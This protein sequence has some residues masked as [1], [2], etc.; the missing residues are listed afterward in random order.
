MACLRGF[1]FDQNM[2]VTHCSAALLSE[3]ASFSRQHNDVDAPCHHN[4]IPKLLRPMKNKP[5]FRSLHALG[6]I[7]ALAVMGCGASQALAE[8]GEPQMNLSR[9]TIRAGM[10]QI[11]AQVAATDLQR[12]TG[13]MWRKQM[14]THEGMLFIFDEPA[15]QCFWMRNTLIPLQIAYLSDD[16]VVVNLI[17]MKPKD[18]T[19]RNCSTKP[20]RYVLEM[21][22]GWFTKRKIAA[23]AQLGGAVF[24]KK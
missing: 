5:P 17:E 6:V 19:S 14:P 15:V 22:K 20:V 1:F 8:D 18:E 21:N 11:D 2:Q 9:T 16:G 10:H 3:F 24:T 23:G 13:L 4:C 12:Q 7:L